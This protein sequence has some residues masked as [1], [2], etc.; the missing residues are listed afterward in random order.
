[1]DLRTAMLACAIFL[2]T[3]TYAD[4][5][6]GSTASDTRAERMAKHDADG[7]GTLSKQEKQAARDAMRERMVARFDTDGDGALSEDERRA[8]KAAI[9][10]ELTARCDTDGDGKLS[11]AERR[12]ARRMLAEQYPGLAKRRFGRSGFGFGHR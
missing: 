10:A 7:D 3:A 4:D 9:R 1:M 5:G 8:A 2:T 12:E 11:G 6:Q